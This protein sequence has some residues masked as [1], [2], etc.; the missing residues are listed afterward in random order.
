MKRLISTG[1]NSTGLNSTGLRRDTS[2][3]SEDTSI[4]PDPKRARIETSGIVARTSGIAAHTS[5]IA[6]PRLR[7]ETP[8][9]IIVNIIDS[10][11]TFGDTITVA[12]RTN[13]ETSAEAE[14]ERL[15]REFNENLESAFLQA[16][17]EIN[18]IHESR[19]IEATVAM[20]EEE[21]RQIQRTTNNFFRQ[22]QELSERSVATLT[23]GQQAQMF[24]QILGFV[25]KNL[26]EAQNETT[27]KEPDQAARLSELA[28]IMYSF[29]MSQ[30]SITL[31]NVYQQ[32]PEKIRQL[33]AIITAVGMAYNYLPESVR[34]LFAEIP[35]FGPLFEIMNAV[36]PNVLVVQNSAAASTTMYYM[37]RNAGLNLDEALG[38]I[39]EF[40]KAAA[41][42]C[43]GKGAAVACAV[44]STV[45]RGLEVGANAV[46]GK[47]GNTLALMI[48]TSYPTVIFRPSE[49]DSQ[50][51]ESSGSSITVTS[52][53]NSLQTQLSL[54]SMRS[55]ESLFG[56]G[57]ATLSEGGILSLAGTAIPEEIVGERF[58]GLNNAVEEG[59]MGI[60]PIILGTETVI[61]A[62]AVIPTVAATP[63]DIIPVVP[64]EPLRR[65]GSVGSNMS[66]LTDDTVTWHE[67]LF[68]P[69]V[70]VATALYEGEGDELAERI[71]GKML[72][73]S[74][75]HKNLK[76]TRQVKRR[77]RGR[78]RQT[79]KGKIHC[80][81]LK[82]YRAKRRK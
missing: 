64:G 9:A 45:Q 46:M 28:S 79:K 18:A 35:T 61:P 19:Q 63:I 27:E 37:L 56:D 22:L 13:T 39:G 36:N 72:R 33:I 60:N 58:I 16:K 3:S 59:I 29:A 32:G 75:R 70:P 68:G 67:W 24:E 23:I 49:G 80:K 51:T 78:G 54:S 66:E 76:K 10:L 82:R 25:T 7:R 15:K 2:F 52:T 53:L 17:A 42:A 14:F 50:S 65:T 47:I 73:K 57:E 21:S 41:S 34:E 81:T 26:H 6:A 8:D 30:L 48:Q 71:G 20:K 38:S 44:S 11:K 12:A 77:G 55:I 43:L 69:S 5:G 40:T 31:T 1:L 4:K 62:V 74:R